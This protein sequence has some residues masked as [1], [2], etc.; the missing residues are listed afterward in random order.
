M[1]KRVTRR[2]ALAGAALL[3]I[4]A[5]LDRLVGDRAGEGGGA[6]APGASVP[7][8]GAHQAGV[9]PADP[10]EAVGAGPARLT[11]TVGFGP[12]LFGSPRERRFGPVGTRMRSRR[13]RRS[14]ALRRDGQ[15]A[16][17]AD[18]HVRLAGPRL[19]GG[20][21]ILR[22]GFSYTEPSQAGS[23]QLDGGLF[24]ICFQRDPRRQFVPIQRRLAA[25][26]A[27]SRHLLHTGSGVFACPPGCK[28]GGFLGEGLFA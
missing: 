6:D 21:R 17:P 28:P 8:Y 25:N 24:F 4:G 19:N 27:L 11:I 14:R 16:I 7:F 2:G 20:R 15:P 18:A 13:C 3:G 10:G 23:G 5:G 9:A 1:S 22:R 12:S 26:D